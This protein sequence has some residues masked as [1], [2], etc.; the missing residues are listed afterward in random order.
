MKCEA[1]VFF[2]D[3]FEAEQTGKKKKILKLFSKADLLIIDD[4]FLRK[5]MPSDAADYLLD[6]ILNRYSKQKSTI[7]TSNRPIEDW[8]LLLKDNAASSAILDRL[9][10]H[11]HLL[12]F[13]RKS[14]RL[15]E[16]AKRLSQKKN[17]D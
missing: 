7:I 4:L 5:R 2:E 15:K 17:Q 11:G 9:L 10:H 12:K 16:A 6:I 8:G 3:M 13:E 14:Y 1:N